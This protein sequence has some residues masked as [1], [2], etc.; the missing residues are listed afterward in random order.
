MYFY[1]MAVL[2]RCTASIF[3]G[4]NSELVRLASPYGITELAH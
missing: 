4:F 3:V 1:T 2:L